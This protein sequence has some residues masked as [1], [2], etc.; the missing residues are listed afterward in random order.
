MGD[1]VYASS[2]CVKNRRGGLVT[3]PPRRQTTLCGAV[4]FDSERI[5]DRATQVLLAPEVSLCCLDRHVSEEKLNLVQLAAGQVAQSCT[6]PSEVVRSERS[7][8]G[9]LRSVPDNLPQDLVAHTITP[10]TAGLVNRS[11][12]TTLED[13]GS[14]G[15][16]IDGGLDPPRHGNRTNVSAFAAM[17]SCGHRNIRTAVW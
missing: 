12:H 5:V 6:R 2:E 7:D 11:E 14:R 10:D 9:C 15:P 1:R 17:F 13:A 8:A 4:R 16:R 3:H